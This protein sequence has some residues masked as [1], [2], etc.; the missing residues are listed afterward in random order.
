MTNA[1]MSL[2]APVATKPRTRV[3]W[4][5]AERAEWLA[6][7]EK[8]GQSVSEFC[9]ANDLPPATLSLWRQSQA[10]PSAGSE[11]GEL[12][13]ISPAALINAARPRASVT[14]RLPG[15]IVLETTTDAD[16][17]WVGALAPR[18]YQPG[19]LLSSNPSRRSA[20]LRAVRARHRF[21]V[22]RPRQSWSEEF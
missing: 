17:T 12:V 8:S 5:P 2:A 20:E 22:L 3:N 18:R 6:L 16:P 15:G 10:E 11:G 13:E 9:R 7:F 1:A 4:T 19:R 21:L 14:I